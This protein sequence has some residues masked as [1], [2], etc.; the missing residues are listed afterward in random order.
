[1]KR[2]V[3]FFLQLGWLAVLGVG[4]W[5]YYFFHDQLISSVGSVPIGVIWFGAVGAVV[6]SLNGVID[7]ARDWDE[8]MYPW[9][10][11]RPVVGG[12]L[13]I[14]GVLILQSGIMAT[15]NPATAS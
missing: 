6:T 9:H 7:H 10:V 4:G 1:M 2:N 14:V 13:A 5:A 12:L 3:M 8:D 11:S 15:G